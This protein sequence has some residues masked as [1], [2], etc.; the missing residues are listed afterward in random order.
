MDRD[1][2]SRQEARVLSDNAKVAQRQLELLDER[3]INEALEIVYCMIRQNIYS[4]VQLFVDES[5]YGNLQDESNIELQLLDS[6]YQKL[7]DQKILGVHQ[8]EVGIARGGV[9]FIPDRKN[10]LLGMICIILLCIKSGNTLII[11][12]NVRAEE[13]TKKLVSL[14]IEALHQKSYPLDV[15]SCLKNV[16]DAGIEELLNYSSLK[17][18]VNAGNQKLVPICRNSGKVFY[19][20]STG[21][22]A[23]FIERSAKIEETVKEIVKSKGFNCGTL[24]GAE[25]FLI[26]DEPV[27]EKVIENLQ[28]EGCYFMSAA[29]EKRLIQILLQG[30]EVDIEQIGKTAHTLAKEAGFFVPENTKLL[31]SY[32]E[33]MSEFDGYRKEI[34]CPVL[35]MYKESDW[36]N[37]C[38]KCIK[39]L[40]SEH[41]GHSLSIYSE[42][43]EIIYQFIT[44]KPVGRVM[45]NTNTT[46]SAMGIDGNITPSAILGAATRGIGSLSGN[47][48]AKD[49]IYQ[50]AIVR[51]DKNI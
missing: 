42:D 6:L 20:G 29:E 15:I 33:Y 16:D 14:V 2:A 35:I 30:R 34:P 47:L 43:E 32:Q 21:A 36:L 27:A 26:V 8:T 24:P 40:T 41:D 25:Q 1:L 17:V 50:R 7:K 5:G 38:E 28:R 51:K 49:L 9:I 11:G 19:Y 46:F 12:T 31:V 45:V 23:V 4:L 39:L 48:E 37:A 18:V 44:K 22:S 10:A 13:T 3:R